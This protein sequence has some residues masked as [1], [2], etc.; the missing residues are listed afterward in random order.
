ML[1][2]GGRQ[3]PYICPILFK[4]TVEILS[5]FKIRRDSAKSE[6]ENGHGLICITV[7]IC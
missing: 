6:N 4:K 1:R 5:C 2:E 3:N 7:K